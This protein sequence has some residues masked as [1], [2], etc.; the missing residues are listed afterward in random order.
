MNKTYAISRVLKPT[1]LF[2]LCFGFSLSTFAQ[3][4]SD[5]GS[6]SSSS[7]SSSSD[8]DSGSGSHPNIP[9]EVCPTPII[10][11]P[12][13]PVTSPSGNFCVNE[14]ITFSAPDLGFPCLTYTWNFGPNATPSTFTGRGPASVVFSSTG[15]RQVSLTIDNGCDA[16]FNGGGSGSSGSG[17]GSDSDSGSGGSGSGSGSDSESGS[18]NPPSGGVICPI[19]GNNGSGSGSDSGSGSGGS[20]SNS[21]DSGSSDS[22]STSG[23]SSG[24]DSSGGNNGGNRGCV[25]CRRT[26]SITINVENCGQAA[27]TMIGDMVFNDLNGNGIMEGGEGGVQ[28]IT[29][30]LS[31]ADGQFVA[32]TTSDFF[33]KYKFSG[34]MPNMSYKLTYT[35]LPAGFSFSPQN[36]GD[37][38]E[39]DSDANPA[40]GMTDPIF[41]NPEDMRLDQD[42]GLV[43][44]GGTGGTVGDRVFADNNGNGIQNG[45]EPGIGGVTVK[46]QDTNG[47]TLQETTTDGNGN[48]SFTG[49]AQGLYKVMFNTP[50][51]FVITIPK[52]GG[53]EET[54]SD[55]QNNQM[56]NPFFVG[57]GQV[58][59]DIDAGYVPDQPNNNTGVIGDRVFADNN[60]NGQQDGGEP[61]I[62]GVTV[63]LQ[64]GNGNTLQETT[65]D[66][67]GNYSFGNLAAGNY[68]VMFNTPNGFIQSPANVGNDNTDSDNQPN[69]MT[70]PFFLA[71]G[72]NNPNIDAGFVPEGTSGGKASVGDF[73][74]RDNNGN[75]VQDPSEPGIPGVFVQLNRG[76]GSFITFK[77]TDQNGHYQFNDLD[78]GSY[79]LK[80]VGQPADLIATLQDAGGDDS[81][82][83][84]IDFL[85]FT[86]VF[87]LS[88]GENNLDFDAGFSP[89]DIVAPTCE[90]TATVSNIRCDGNTYSF[91]VTVTGTNTGDWGWDIGAFGIFM[92]NYGATRR[93]SG[94]SGTKAITVRDHD[95]PDCTTTFTVSPPA[96]CGDN[97]G[98]NNGGGNNGGG[99]GTCS[100]INISTNNGQIVI[101]GLTAP[102]EITKIF[103]ASWNLIYQCS[104]N[105]PNTITESVSNGD[106]TVQVQFYT[107]Q[108][109]FIC[110][111]QVSVTVGG[112]GGNT[113][114]GGSNGGGNSSGVDCDNITVQ[115]SNG[116]ISV[117]GY[118]APVAI[119]KIFNPDF[120]IAKECSGNNCAGPITATGLR[121]G[122]YHIDVQLYTANWESICNFTQDVTLG[123]STFTIP[124]TNEHL[125]EDNAKI[126]VYPNPTSGH[127]FVNM[128][129]YAGQT[130]IFRIQNQMGQIVQQI[131]LDELPT[132]AVQLATS[133]LNDGLYYLSAAI[134][135]KQVL[136]EKVLI[137]Q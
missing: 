59:N 137:K 1:F 94:V 134:G 112:S 102:I 133:G 129:A 15:S 11:T 18:F 120:S 4:G 61:G 104:G 41:L 72:E 47:N 9:P 62:G 119:V 127:L 73:V 31:K 27:P 84:D 92:E 100:D 70:D 82:D 108:W 105:C 118:S 2:L 96:G 136:M 33:G 52:Q 29:V 117:S 115:A 37:N 101:S 45:G 87:T 28:G 24:T 21:G 26:V 69:Q 56:T 132:D 5:S 12:T 40:T 126:A 23:D 3:S 95:I 97:G 130:G 99:T 43:Q 36:Q 66:G 122:T 13:S 103:D 113:G 65:T 98:G 135:G 63:K 78:P 131:E 48:Y 81:R 57:Q 19:G 54:D 60:G 109:G 53:V 38:E 42:V 91:D 50:N 79:Q 77:L 75:G 17:S 121:A 39:N 6:S 20:D 67:N 114:G 44:T 8:S 74:F 128:R 80:I 88:A 49:V 76:D 46:L 7:S 83:S 125:S 55:V 22:G 68:K 123:S 10:N 116:Q 35:N 58:R 51:G 34:V 107:A 110:E 124:N 71:Q 30:T 89:R 93:I 106:Y 16:N 25:P 64:D 86:D 111:E 90:I 14:P 32:Q 85:G